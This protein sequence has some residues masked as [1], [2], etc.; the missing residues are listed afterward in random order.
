MNHFI[1][2]HPG[3]IEYL[4]AIESGTNNGSNSNNANSIRHSSNVKA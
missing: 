2:K 4:K 1:E 3:G